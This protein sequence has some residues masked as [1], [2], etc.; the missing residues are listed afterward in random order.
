MF[1]QRHKK[2]HHTSTTDKNNIR[3]MEVFQKS[4]SY[5]KVNPITTAINNK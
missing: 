3:I 2:R 4:N 5:A 1:L